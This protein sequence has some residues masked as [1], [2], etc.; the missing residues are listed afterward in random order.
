MA[1][2]R[3]IN[4][5]ASVDYAYLYTNKGEKLIVSD[6][7]YFFMILTY[8]INDWKAICKMNLNVL[9]FCWTAMVTHYTGIQNQ[10]KY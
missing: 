3:E 4:R 1:A 7:K 10:W 8:K 6:L 5:V 2:K 9:P